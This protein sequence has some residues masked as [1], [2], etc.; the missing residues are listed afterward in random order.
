MKDEQSDG[1]LWTKS[2]WIYPLN[3][4]FVCIRMQGW[5]CFNLASTKD[6]LIFHQELAL[7]DA[8][9]INQPRCTIGVS[10]LAGLISGWKVCFVAIHHPAGGSKADGKSGV[11]VRH[12]RLHT[13]WIQGAAIRCTKK[14]NR[15][16]W[17]SELKRKRRRQQ[18]ITDGTVA[19]LLLTKAEI[20]S[21]EQKTSKFTFS[22]RHKKEESLIPHKSKGCHSENCSKCLNQLM[23]AFIGVSSVTLAAI[24]SLFQHPPP[25]PQLAAH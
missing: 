17:G 21:P 22:E 4:I 9:L 14:D 5:A 16:W 1:T 13:K 8:Q 25:P 7:P 12:V 11:I 6:T 19:S 2:R 10:W 24:S 23:G 3:N 15:G 20:F 18:Q